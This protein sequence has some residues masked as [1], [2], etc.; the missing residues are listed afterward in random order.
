MDTGGHASKPVGDDSTRNAGE[1]AVPIIR[2]TQASKPLA[3][4]RADT[5]AILSAS[6]WPIIFDCV[7]AVTA[8]RRQ[9]VFARVCD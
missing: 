9:L 1:R 7:E 8:A 3:E 4:G 2:P 5:I 6:Q